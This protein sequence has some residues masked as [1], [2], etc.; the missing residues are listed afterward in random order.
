MYTK[1]HL[2]H[3]PIASNAPDSVHM[4]VP[5]QSIILQ[6]VLLSM[7]GSRYRWYYLD[8][9]LKHELEVSSEPMLP[10]CKT[11]ILIKR[12]FWNFLKRLIRQ[13]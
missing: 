11:V 9:D 5:K 12:R 8:E 13:P 4:A 6:P 3:I 2:A 7:Q 1:I 10:S